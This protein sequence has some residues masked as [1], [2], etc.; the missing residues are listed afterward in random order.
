MSA[1]QPKRHLVTTEWSIF[2][3]G[4][5]LFA[6]DSVLFIR[7]ANRQLANISSSVLSSDSMHIGILAAAAHAFANNSPFT[8]FYNPRDSPS[9]FVIPLAKYYK[10]VYASM[11]LLSKAA[12]SK[13]MTPFV[14]V[15][16]R[17]AFASVFLSSFSFFDS[18]QSAPLSGK[19]LCNLF[20]ISLVGLTTSS[21]LS[22]I[23]I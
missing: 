9:E 15:V 16:Y 7:L 1:G 13:G 3:S 22:K 18:K 14:F 8:V 2:V 5:R 6:R 19:L 17:Q 21:T 10:F 23:W 12:I 20:L 4:K 11:A